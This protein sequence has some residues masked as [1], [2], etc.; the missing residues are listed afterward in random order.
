[1]PK[2]T[3]QQL[4]DLDACP[5]QT[6]LFEKTFGQEVEITEE[7]CEKYAAVFDFGWAVDRLL[8]DPYEDAANACDDAWNTLC[9]RRILSNLAYKEDKLTIYQIPIARAFARQY[10]LEN[11]K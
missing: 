9:S 8:N 2:V 10:I 4:Y 5:E 3:L 1:M 7:L 11:P 6:R